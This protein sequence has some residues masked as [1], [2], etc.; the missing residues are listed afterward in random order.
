M[1]IALRVSNAVRVRYLGDHT[2]PTCINT[3]CHCAPPALKKATR[4]AV[5]P[6]RPGGVD[7]MKYFIAD[8]VS[9]VNPSL[10]FLWLE[11]TGKCQ[12]RCVHCYADSGPSGTH[13]AMER[14]DWYRVIDEAAALGVQMVQFIGGEPTMH[15]D[16]P[17]LI[18][19]ALACGL[20]VEVFSNLVHVRPELW[21]LF[22]RPGV[23]LATSYYSDDPAQH[24]E[25]TRRRNSYTRTRSNIV[26]AVRHSIPIRVGI[27]DVHDNQ[28]AE[29][30]RAELMSLGVTD[31]GYDRL[32]QVG[33]GIRNQKQDI[34]QLCGRCSSGVLAVSSDGSVWP[35]VFARWLPVGDV[36]ALSLAEII[37][38]DQLRSVRDELTQHFRTRQEQ[39]TPSGCHPD[40]NPNHTCEPRCEPYNA[41]CHP[42]CG[43][44]CG[45]RCNPTN[46]RPN[47]LPPRR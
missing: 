12:L 28:R 45:P 10:S 24:E 37:A 30:A 25:I 5:P 16:L 40:C 35:C 21:E 13:G 14:S 9:M 17:C 36:R 19:H 26:E 33:R 18:D 27:I 23:H 22:D 34:T 3:K 2:T 4:S 38:G 15:P 6:M 20:E 32:R 41:G 39:N 8:W 7:W 43:P 44:A 11:I 42:E 1:P 46:C 29:H 31:I 47:C